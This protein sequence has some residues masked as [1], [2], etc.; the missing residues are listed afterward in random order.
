MMVLGVVFDGF[1]NVDCLNVQMDVVV[2]LVVNVKY[3]SKKVDV[4]VIMWFVCW[5]VLLCVLCSCMMFVGF[6]I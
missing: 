1:D 6:V 4:I 5:V 3:V 2:V